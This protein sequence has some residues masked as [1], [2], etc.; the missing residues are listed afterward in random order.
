MF[1][2]YALISRLIDK[3]VKL[4]KHRIIVGESDAFQ[5]AQ[6]LKMDP[7]INSDMDAMR[8]LGQSMSGYPVTLKV[9]KQFAAYFRF[10]LSELRAGRRLTELGPFMGIAEIVPHPTQRY[11]KPIMVLIN[12]LDFSAADL[13]PAI[14]QDSGRAKLFGARTAGAGGAVRPMEFPN[15]FGIAQIAYTWTLAIRKNGQPIENLGVRPDIRYRLTEGDMTGGFPGYKGAL[16]KAMRRMLKQ[17]P[18]A[19]K[20]SD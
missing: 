16:N 9:W 6:A 10:V 18:A 7:M 11:T 14:L 3:P 15:Q 2:T 19:P 8:A 13:L 17:A 20:N 4:P 5:A 1:H 12:Q